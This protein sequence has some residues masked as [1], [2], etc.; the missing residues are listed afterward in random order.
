MEGREVRELGYW[1]MEDVG[2]SSFHS[3][4]NQEGV[5]CGMVVAI[6]L[7][8]WP[9]SYNFMNFVLKMENGCIN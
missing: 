5:K 4:H 7:F 6:S 8:L 1:G 9:D 2:D 3:E